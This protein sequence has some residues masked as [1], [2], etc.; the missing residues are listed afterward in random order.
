MTSIKSKVVL[1]T[2]ASSGIGE[3]TAEVLAKAGHTVLVAARRTD[4]LEALTQRIKQAG[5]TAKAY[6]LDVTSR[7]NFKAVVA[8]ASEEFCKNFRRLLPDICF[9]F[10]MTIHSLVLVVAYGLFCL[11]YCFACFAHVGALHFVKQG[12]EFIR[13]SKFQNGSGQHILDVTKCI[14]YFYDVPVFDSFFKF[15]EFLGYQ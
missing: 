11:S 4:R 12:F 5:G 1:I 13:Q 10:I 8:A 9:F 6:A 14:C 2:G 15:F 3:T 7:E